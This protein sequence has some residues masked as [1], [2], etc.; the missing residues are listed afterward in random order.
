ML[1]R[2][3]RR[4]RSVRS[5]NYSDADIAAAFSFT[6]EELAAAAVANSINLPVIAEEPAS[7]PGKVCILVS[8]H[9]YSFTTSLCMQMLV[10]R[11]S[12]M[13]YQQ[14]T[15]LVIGRHRCCQY[16]MMRTRCTSRIPVQRMK[17]TGRSV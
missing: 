1:F 14:S 10:L 2:P 8:I 4:V 9:L 15:T 12:S 5:G 6:P 11:Q 7:R 16:I 3:A 17:K 13:V